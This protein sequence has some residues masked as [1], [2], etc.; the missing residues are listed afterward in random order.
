MSRFKFIHIRK[1]H[2]PD[3]KELTPPDWNSDISLFYKIHRDEK[4]F[5][6][7]GVESDG[8][9]IACGFAIINSKVAWLGNIVVSNN[10]RKLGLGTEITSL[11]IAHCKNSGCATLLLIATKLGEPVYKKLGFQTESEY[12]FLKGSNYLASENENSIRLVAKPDHNEILKLDFNITGERR[13]PLIKKFL[14]TGLL[15]VN[16]ENEIDG[17]Y[18][19]DFGNGFIIAKNKTAGFELL[20][21]KHIGLKS[22]VVVPAKNEP[23]IK[24][25]LENNFNEFLRAPRMILGE[26]ILWKQEC[27]FSRA[28]GYCG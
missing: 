2:L 8:K 17:F 13:E 12:V 16:D 25:L 1:K 23:A 4:Y 10:F 3:L 6:A 26:K 22:T 28:A 14:Q 11:L 15:H 18:L 19:P 7:I 9:L 24:Y 5:H 27:I 20:R 21:R